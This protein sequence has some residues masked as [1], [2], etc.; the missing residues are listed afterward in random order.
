[1]NLEKILDAAKVLFRN[2]RVVL[3]DCPVCGSQTAESHGWHIR[4]RATIFCPECVEWGE[5]IL[6]ETKRRACPK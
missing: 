4:N 2:E 3:S 1:M 6:R 5:D